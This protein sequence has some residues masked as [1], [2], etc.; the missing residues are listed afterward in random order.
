M[1]EL[2]LT[3]VEYA[4]VGVTSPQCMCVLPN[5][6]KTKESRAGKM[7][8]QRVAV[9]DHDGVLTCFQ[10]K[11]SEAVPIYKTLPGAAIS[12]V[13][14][15]G[16]PGAHADH[17]FVAAGNA[18]RGY[19][20]KG[21]QFLGFESNMTEPITC[22]HVRGADL[23]LCGNFIYNHYHDLIDTNYFLAG[24][25]INDVVCVGGDGG[26]PTPVLACNDKLMRVLRDSQL[27]YEVETP[28]P[29]TALALH[30]G[31]GGATGDEITYGTDDGHVAL[32]RVGMTTPA[33]GWVVGGGGGGSVTALDYYDVTG[34][35]T[36]DLIVGRD[37][38]VLE[39]YGFHDDDAEED[40]EPTLRFSHA[41]NEGITAV[42]GGVV[43]AAGHAEVAMTTY[44][45]AVVGMTTERLRQ[46][47]SAAAGS[48]VSPRA[49]ERVSRLRG[50]IDELT[51]N[52]QQ[53]RERYQAATRRDDGVSAI[54]Q[55][56]TRVR[57]VLSSDDASYALSI[58]CQTAI[59]NVLLQS[60]VPVDLL[61][62]DRNSAVVSH[63]AADPGNSNFLLATYRCQ[64]NTTRLELKVRSIEGQYGTLRAYV[65]PRLQPKTCIVKTFAVKPLSL[66]RSAHAYDD[67]RPTNTLRLD[68]QFSYA[69]MHAW[70]AACLPDVAERPGAGEAACLHFVSTFLDTQLE[71]MYRKGEAVFRSDNV[72]TI[73]ILK[74][75]I[76]KEATARKIHLEI[77]YEVSDDSVSHVLATIHPKLEH[78]L[79]LA[80][81]VRLVEALRELAAHDAD[82]DAYLA[83]E[84][85]AILRDD[86]ALRREFREQPCQLERL[87]G[88]VTDL[89]IDRHKFRGADVKARVPQLLELLD[90]YELQPLIAFFKSA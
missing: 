87:Y 88:M 41:C 8:T 64:A 84:Y 13:T 66:H 61:D 15:A 78:Q 16:T 73:S 7:A 24:D 70:I 50:E 71:C 17:V 74:D 79:A 85:R 33:H 44:A 81:K 53:E 1:A 14:L 68:G 12:R 54:P 3:R 55:L 4:Q 59:D 22:M 76:T 77:N 10:M 58:E 11:R 40:A 31:T 27:L 65:T 67:A 90:N 69:E 23:L 19:A 35:G 52:V 82:A 46:E 62:V 34:D 26:A 5:V 18:V 60:D 36:L 42:R 80:K 39:V 37:D 72:S 2:T 83:A 6:E 30:R 45:G 56:Q 89:F 32:L 29:P 21:K 75:F 49:L 20:R 9:G 86:D 38:G 48:T 51:S 47:S 57:F 43:G 28:A 63:A 25:R